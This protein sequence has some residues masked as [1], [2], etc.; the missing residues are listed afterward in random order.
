MRSIVGFIF[1]SIFLVALMPSDTQAGTLLGCWETWSRCTKWSQ[2]G[3]GI[4]W[5]NCNNRCKELG[6]SSGLCEKRRSKCR[7]SKNA[8]A[9]I[10]Y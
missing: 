9:C 10:C 5:K 8:W 1:V 7:F 4:L 3:T 6:H 2:R